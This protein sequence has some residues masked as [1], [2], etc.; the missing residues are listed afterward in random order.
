MLRN[1]GPVL[2]SVA[3]TSQ[4]RIQLVH[5]DRLKPFP[6]DDAPFWVRDKIMALNEEAEAAVDDA[7]VNSVDEMEEDE[8]GAS[9]NDD[10]SVQ[11]EAQLE[12]QLEAQNRRRK[13]KRRKQATKERDSSSAP[14]T[15]TRSNRKVRPPRRYLP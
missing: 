14:L 9:N 8:V 6:K 13:T 12:P 7:D 15:T 3:S 5:A 11:E 1:I 10:N 2:H 4:G